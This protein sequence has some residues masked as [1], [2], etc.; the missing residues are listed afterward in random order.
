MSVAPYVEVCPAQLPSSVCF[1]DNWTC[2][3]SGDCTAKYI[4]ACDEKWKRKGK[5]PWAM[6]LP[7]WCSFSIFFGS[8]LSPVPFAPSFQTYSWSK[9]SILATVVFHEKLLC[10]SNSLYVFS[11]TCGMERYFLSHHTASILNLCSVF[12]CGFLKVFWKCCEAMEQT[13]I[14]STS[15]WMSFWCV[16][17]LNRRVIKV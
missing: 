17:A 8:T 5:A 13:A 10:H 9:V 15:S 1:L 11:P 14:V 6:V 2:R 4:S 7:I 3:I 16:L 12:K